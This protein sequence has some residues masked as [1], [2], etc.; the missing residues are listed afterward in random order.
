MFVHTAKI[1]EGIEVRQGAVS[2]VELADLSGITCL[3]SVILVFNL[4]TVGDLSSSLPSGCLWGV[5][6]Y[7]AGAAADSKAPL[8]HHALFQQVFP[9]VTPEGWRVGCLNFWTVVVR[10]SKGSG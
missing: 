7:P 2:L 6:V 8:L 1:S 4:L 3:G 5:L 9:L 10:W